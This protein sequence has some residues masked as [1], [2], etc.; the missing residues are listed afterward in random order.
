MPPNSTFFKDAAESAFFERELEFVK[1]RTYDKVYPEFKARQFIP[2]DYSVPVG[3][4]TVVYQQFDM[5]GVAK[6]ISSYADDL[7]RADIKGQEFS[8]PVKTIGSSYAYNLDEIEAAMMAGTPLEQRKAN[9]A[10]FACEAE[11]D[12]IASSGDANNN[13]QGLLGIANA[14]AYTVAN[15]A[16]G[17]KPWSS[18]TNAE[19]LADLG[20]IV[21]Y[22]REQT[23]GAE[24]PDTILLPEAQYADIAQAQLSSGV[25]ETVLSFFLRTN[26]YIKQVFPWAKLTGAGAGSTDRMVA[27][28]RDPDKLGL[29]IPLEFEQRPAQERNLEMAVPCRMKTGGVLCYYPLSVAYGDGI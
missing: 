18:K 6:I 4:K 23:K 27:Y 13:L 2:P 14:L 16:S 1:S 3:A 15:G 21:T 28:K 17:S 12:R 24:T 20:G 8:S 26:P 11:L 5:V 22:I 7:P 25:A 29:V 10:R 9:A 19:K